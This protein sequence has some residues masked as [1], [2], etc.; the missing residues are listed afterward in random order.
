MSISSSQLFRLLQHDCRA[1]NTCSDQ[2]SRRQK[3]SYCCTG[4]DREVAPC[5]L[6]SASFPGSFCM[7]LS[8]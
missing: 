4:I 7:A 8:A 2:K 6:S 1:V 3:F 5:K